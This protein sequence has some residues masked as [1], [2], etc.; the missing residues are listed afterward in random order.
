MDRRLA[1]MAGLNRDSLSNETGLLKEWPK[2]GPKLL[3][4]VNDLGSGYA[5]PS[6]VGGRIFLMSNKGLED[7]FVNALAVKV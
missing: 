5:T 4:Q 3:W 2:E 6:I 7:E 1:A